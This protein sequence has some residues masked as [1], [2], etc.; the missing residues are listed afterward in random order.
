[1]LHVYLYWLVATTAEEGRG[2]PSALPESVLLIVI[3]GFYVVWDQVVLRMRRSDQYRDMDPSGDRPRRRY[4][5]ATALGLLILFLP[6]AIFFQSAVAVI[7]LDCVLVAVLIGHRA[8]QHYFRDSIP[9]GGTG[10]PETRPEEPSD[11]NGE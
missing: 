6:L 8:W 3:F 1:M 4:V 11:G 7:T 5:T 2:L 10:D 9:H